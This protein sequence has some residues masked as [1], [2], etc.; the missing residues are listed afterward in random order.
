MHAENLRM[1]QPRPGG[2]Y[3]PAYE[4][5]R[6]EYNDF[7]YFLP[8]ALIEVDLSSLQIL[9]ANRMAEIVIGITPEDVEAG[10]NGTALVD[11][12]DMPRLLELMQ[13]YAGESRAKNSPYERTGR[14]AIHTATLR[15]RDGST[16]LAETQSSFVLD[17]RGVPV[18]MLTIIRDISY[19]E[20]QADG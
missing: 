17:S 14:Q 19:R 7:R 15:R 13:G 1:S 2:D 20:S 8:D 9:Y 5:L 4:A 11:G 6:R 3:R 18:R 10:L 12:P 16:F